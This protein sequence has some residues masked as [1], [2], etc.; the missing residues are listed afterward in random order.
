MAK[1]VGTNRFLWQGIALFVVSVALLVSAGLLFDLTKNSGHPVTLF[2]L[3]LFSLGMATVAMFASVISF[4]EHVDELEVR[5]RSFDQEMND[6]RREFEAEKAEFEVEVRAFEDRVRAFEDKDARYRTPGLWTV[7]T[8]T[9]PNGVRHR[10]F[11][12]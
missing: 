3:A 10:T 2:L 8:R 7:E 11:R 12:R 1:R 9:D 6:A 4:G 5:A